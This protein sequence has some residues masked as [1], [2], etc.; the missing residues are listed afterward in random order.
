MK[1][2]NEACVNQMGHGETEVQWG[3]LGFYWM[4]QGIV[5]EI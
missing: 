4:L 2:E 5:K 1:Y 3:F